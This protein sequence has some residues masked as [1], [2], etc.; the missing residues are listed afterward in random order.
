MTGGVGNDLCAV[1][2]CTKIDFF[3][4]LRRAKVCRTET[5]SKRAIGFPDGVG[6]TPTPF[7]REEQASKK[8]GIATKS[9]IRQSGYAA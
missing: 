1:S 9:H 4:S 5:P 2:I 7:G 3:D 6:L 8:D